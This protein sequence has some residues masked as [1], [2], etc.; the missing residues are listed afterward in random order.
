M[1]NRLSGVTFATA[2]LLLLT[3]SFSQAQ[4]IDPLTG[5]AAVS[6]PICK[7]GA[8]DLSMGVTLSHHGGSLQ[9]NEV[10]GNA[11]MGWNLIMGGSVSREVRGLPDD[12][13]LAGDARTGWLVNSNA[14]ASLIQ[15]FIPSGDNN[16]SV[17]SDE[18]PDWTFINNLSYIK[19]AEPDVFYFNAPGLSGKFVFGADGLPKLVPY[20]DVQITFTYAQNSTVIS[21]F[22]IKTN[23]G[24]VYTF[25]SIVTATRQAI[26]PVAPPSNTDYLYYTSPLT[27]NAA[28]KL[29]SIQSNASG[30]TAN[31]TYQSTPQTYGA[32]YVSRV[33]PPQSGV[34]SVDTLYYLQETVNPKRLTLI[35]LKNYSINVSWANNLI[36]K[37]SISE[38]ETGDSQEF[39]FIYKSITSTSDT[40]YPKIAKPFLIQV[41]QQ[42]SGTC[43]ALPSFRFD[44]VNVDTVALQANIPWR[45]G[46]GEDFFGY[47][48]GQDNNQNIPT[49]YYY[50]AEGGARRY[51]VT[52]IPSGAILT[53]TLS[54]PTGTTMAPN[55]TYTSFGALKKI[56][57]PTGGTTTYTYESNKYLDKT[58]R[59][60]LFGPGVRVASVTTF[61]GEV[62]FGKTSGTS[63][64]HS[65]TK[66][67]QY[68][69][70]AGDT[71]SGRITYPPSFGYTDGTNVN[72]LQSDGGS[73]GQVMYT[74][75]TES[76]SGR[77]YTEYIFDVP[78]TYPDASTAATWSKVARPTGSTCT[79]A[80]LMNGSYSY[81][82]APLKDLSYQRG[83]PLSVSDYNSTGSLTRQK[84]MTYTSVASGIVI[85]GLRYELT[86]DFF[87]YSL[88]DIALNES[89]RL[90]EEIT[91]TYSEETPSAFSTVTTDYLYNSQNLP[92]QITVT[93]GD[94][95]VSKQY[96]RYSSY[97]NNITAPA[98]GDQQANAIFKLNS[99]NRTAEVIET[100]QTFT[101]AQGTEA[102]AGATLNIYKDYGACVWPYQVQSFV[103]GVAGTISATASNS[104]SFTADA[105]YMVK[106]PVMDFV[107]GL[108][109]NQT[110]PVSKVTMGTHYATGTATPLANF[111]NCKA[112][113]AVY[114]GFELVQD[115]G[116]T[117]SGTGVSVQSTGWTGKKSLQFGSANSTV[118]STAT[119]TKRGT[120]YRVSCWFY[121]AQ[122]S[123]LTVQ[124]K[125][126]ATVQSS[127]V[128]NYTTPNQWKYL[129]GFMDVTAVS[130]AFTLQLVANNTIQIDDF[131]AMPKQAR[132]SYTSYLP[133]TGVTA[134]TDDRGNSSKMDYDSFGRPVKSYDRQRNLKEV[135][136]YV[137]QRKGRI[138]LSANFTANKVQYVVGQNVTFTA[139]AV[140]ACLTPV[141]Y[142]WAITDFNNTV[143]NLTGT[144]VSCS[145]PKY[146][147]YSVT[148][149]ASTTVAG[150][151]PVSYTE[152]ICVTL[153]NTI[154]PTVSVSGGSNTIYF[155]DPVGSNVRTFTAFVQEINQAVMQNLPVHYTWYVATGNGSWV[156]AGWV[157]YVTIINGN[158]ITCNS[159]QSN[160]Q[161]MY[162]VSFA[163]NNARVNA[164]TN[165]NAQAGTV[166]SST[167]SI[168][169]VNNS[170][171]Q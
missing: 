129:E 61:G 40:G 115:K 98:A 27:Y 122:N 3:F 142:S 134:Q 36:D 14:N 162:V 121:A 117:Y 118:T 26:A 44:Y 159:P 132:V 28:W 43:E 31:L 37:I 83:Y 109:M 11:G 50:Q 160:Y 18:T 161:V 78:N 17:C 148:L 97:F 89:K 113:N 84:T 171:C 46:F 66:N 2:L 58:T 101:P 167:A 88:Y 71:T 137:T 21:S 34:S 105:N 65:I 126:G 169:F 103:Q 16:L 136:E 60:E 143:T 54:G 70:V 82:F 155:C 5:R 145:F 30:A 49:L 100:Y 12:Y 146:G 92:K 22:T 93:N 158:T 75:V 86:G 144:N 73:G 48:N 87:Q 140:P 164:A 24:M 130:A 35:S 99:N 165:C 107:N 9:V 8:L 57:I 63:G 90:S 138:E 141:T 29:T 1:L 67:Y 102:M 47:Y 68:L 123:T 42:N 163:P 111:A 45:R 152:N 168:T 15:G 52:P 85:R 56:Q 4:D 77:G 110:D 128:L 10:A 131:V 153:P 150:Y 108:P 114:E 124:A 59:E 106:G 53:S 74:R 166:S 79:N 62:A 7:I 112:E 151:S 51:R 157:P 147:S 104:T 170:P 95:S 80:L 69:K 76:V 139:P 41:R 119:L 6:L 94:Q 96:I 156:E 116:L 25:S 64:F 125:N 81:P 72:R 23:K 135:R 32:N 13:S 20:Q 55:N 120:T 33:N 154:T 133:L 39:D 19:D 149:T 127:V 38:S 91:K